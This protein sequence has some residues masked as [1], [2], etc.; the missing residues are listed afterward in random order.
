MIYLS[1]GGEPLTD[2]RADVASLHLTPTAVDGCSVIWSEQFRDNRGYFGETFHREDFFKAG[3][4]AEWPQ[5]NVSN[6][7]EWV[8]RGLHIQRNNP[9]GKLVRCVKGCIQDICLD[10]RPE[11]PTYLK[12]HMQLIKGGGSMYCPPGTAHGFLAMVPRTIV[13][14]KCTTLYDKD[15]DGGINPFDPDLKIPWPCVSPIVSEKDR[16][17]PTLKQWLEDPRGLKNV[18]N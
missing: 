17:L 13:Y 7:E 11:S 9:Q 16:N 15:S 8:L 12:Y 18:R 10:L 14:Y 5:D 6:S 3:L 2:G 4:P 1:V